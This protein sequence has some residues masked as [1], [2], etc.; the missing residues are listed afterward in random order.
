MVYYAELPDP[1][2]P[3]FAS[4]AGDC[5]HNMRAALDHVV[6]ELAERV[7]GSP[8]PDDV[9]EA[10]EFPVTGPK[11]LTERTRNKKIGALPSDAQDVIV[12]LQPSTLGNDFAK[13]KLWLLHDLERID[14]HRRPLVA[15]PVFT[16][17]S[18]S[19]PA[20]AGIQQRPGGRFKVEVQLNVEARFDG[21]TEM[22]RFPV[23]G[24]DAG[25]EPNLEIGLL[26]LLADDFPAGGNPILYVL[27]ELFEFILT[28]VARP[29]RRYL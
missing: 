17:M 24:V 3:R 4:L 18:V 2:F 20:T 11:P 14:K 27:R 7:L 15:S 29:L 9:A 28:D 23:R 8:L 25:F 13:H 5:L 21:R 16:D 6:Y 12:A 1:P 22:T 10:S 26:V 19:V